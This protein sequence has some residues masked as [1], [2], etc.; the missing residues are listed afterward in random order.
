MDTKKPKRG[1][2]KPG[3]SGNP[4]GRPA[5]TSIAGKL[6]DSISEH[7]PEII[8]QLVSRAKQGDTQAAR[9]LLERIIPP[10]KPIEEPVTLTLPEGEGLTAHGE[11]IMQAVAAGKVVPGQAAALLGGLASVAR[12]KEIDELERRVATLESG[13]P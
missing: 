9:L 4:K 6:R 8:A 10:M 11:A 3:E 5:G 7:V 2:W 1:R 13:N 12:L